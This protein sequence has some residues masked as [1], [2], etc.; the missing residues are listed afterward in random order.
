MDTPVV[1]MSSLPYLVPLVEHGALHPTYA[2]VAVDH[3][4]GDVAVH[5][6]TKVS[7][8]TVDGDG[9]PI[10]KADT[11]ETAGY[12]DPRSAPWRLAERTCARSPSG[13]RTWW[14]TSRRTSFC[15]R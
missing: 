7:A 2:V 12:G 13:W 9:Y 6:D 4:G 3:T 14:T 15:R 1:R 5:R 11:A 8:E 10:H